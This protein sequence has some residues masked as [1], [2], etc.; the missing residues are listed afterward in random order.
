MDC[1]FIMGFCT[2]VHYNTFILQALP[3]LDVNGIL[4]AIAVLPQ[5]EQLAVFDQ[6]KQQLAQLNITV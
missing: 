3:A 1:Q 4:S 6:L 2:T 5:E